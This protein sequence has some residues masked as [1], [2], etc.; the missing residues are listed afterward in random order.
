MTAQKIRDNSQ[1]N[2]KWIPINFKISKF[3]RFSATSMRFHGVWALI[4]FEL[5]FNYWHQHVT[6]ILRTGFPR[7]SW[8]FCSSTQSIIHATPPDRCLM[9]FAQNKLGAVRRKMCY[10]F[11]IKNEK[12]TPV[13]DGDDY[14]F[15]GLREKRIH[16]S[17]HAVTQG[18]MYWPWS[19][20]PRAVRYELR[21]AAIMLFSIPRKGHCNPLISTRGSTNIPTCTMGSIMNANDQM[22]QDTTQTY[23][24]HLIPADGRLSA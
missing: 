1:D 11:Q 14:M 22:N 7:V 13:S 16:T 17:T 4:K 24:M 8:S 12:D 20:D 3:T 5:P 23:P 10:F 9:P 15:C 6:Y 19:A 18:K 2:S 21:T